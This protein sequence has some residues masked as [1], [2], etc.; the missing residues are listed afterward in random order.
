ME[1]KLKDFIESS[2]TGDSKSVH[3]ALRGDTGPV[4]TH[5]LSPGLINHISQSK[6]IISPLH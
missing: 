2:G 3:M 5:T 4:H 1:E 6:E